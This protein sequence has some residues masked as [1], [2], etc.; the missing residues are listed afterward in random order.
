[1]ASE[2]ARVR[3]VWSRRVADERKCVDCGGANFAFMSPVCSACS[4]RRERESNR[5]RWMEESARLARRRR[6]ERAELQRAEYL[7]ARMPLAYPPAVP[8]RGSVEELEKA[9]DKLDKWQAVAQAM[10]KVTRVV[11]EEPARKVAG[12]LG[13]F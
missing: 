5:T 6:L 8:K 11:G 3:A 13:R 10:N 12:Y 9:L 7:H 2:K 1:M 4:G